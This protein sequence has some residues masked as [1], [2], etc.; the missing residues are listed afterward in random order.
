MS[1]VRTFLLFVI[2]GGIV[3]LYY[4]KVKKTPEVISSAS[5]SPFQNESAASYILSL[6]GGETIKTLKLE[7]SLERSEIWLEQ[8]SEHKWQIKR[9]VNDRAESVV[10]DG[11][12]S[13][14][15]LAPRTRE[16]SFQGVNP[17]EFGFD[18]PGFK[19]CVATNQSEKER[20]LLIG[21]KAVVGD[22]LYAKW[23]HEPKFFVINKQFVEVFDQSLYALRKKQIF[24][25]LDQTIESVFFRSQTRELEIRREGKSWFLSKPRQS[26]AGPDSVSRL[27]T[28][29]NGLFVKE[30]LDRENWRNSKLGLKP[31]VKMV[32]IRFRDGSEQ[33]LFLGREAAGREAYYGYLES[34]AVVVLISSGK[35]NKIEQ[36]FSELGG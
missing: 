4:Q 34:R 31:P 30:F 35:F 36:I 11:F 25:V 10:I 26:M 8:L 18:R 1:Q 19:V 32:R 2:L 17:K 21:E 15:K 33:S 24:H 7:D 20:C 22:G 3:F 9:P 5:V 13:L 6:K 29:L 23:E 16:I 14:L 27:M 12:T 28:Q